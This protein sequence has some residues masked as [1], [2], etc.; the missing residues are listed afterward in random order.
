MIN[1]AD[2]IYIGTSGWD[3]PGWRSLFYPDDL[4]KEDWL[5]YYTQ[6]FR[7]LEI[8]HSFYQLPKKDT[9]VQWR[10]HVPDGFQFAIKASRYITHNKN[11]KDSEEPVANFMDR[12]MALE[13]ALGPILFQLPPNW[14]CNP[15]RLKQFLKILPE[16]FEYSFE[17]R[18]RTW[19]CPEIYDLLTQ[20]GAAF[21]IFDL[22]QQPSE[23]IITADHIYIRL[24]GPNTEPYTGHYPPEALACWVDTF[25]IW[26]QQGKRIYCYFNN[27]KDGCAPQDALALQEQV[28][29][30]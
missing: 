24:H 3:Y 15:E 12:V 29:K 8:N 5:A 16:G 19:H 27:D 14:H 6:H 4:P 26:S 25:A 11:L 10:S 13:D 20:H 23:P 21:C 17:F 2:R 22:R 18:D 30:H 28:N 9:L 7:T 1:Q